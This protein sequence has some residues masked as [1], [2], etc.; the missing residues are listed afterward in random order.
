VNLLRET[1]WDALAAF[2][3][4]AEQR[5]FT[6]AAQRLHLSQPALHTKVANLAH[7]LGVTLYERRGRQIEITDA[8]RKVQRFARELEANAMDFAAELDDSREGA[9]VVLCAGE[10]AYL[11]LL[12]AGIRAHR[13]SATHPLRLETAGAEGALDAV[14]SARAHLGVAALERSPRHLAVEPLT[15]VGQVLAVP[16]RHALAGHRSAR[17][18]DLDGAAL[19]VPPQGRP[20][21]SMLAQA[22]QS[23]NVKWQVAV[24]ANGWELMLHFV[25]LGLGLA[26]VNECCRMPA[27]VVSRPLPELPALQF[28]V[29]HARKGVPDAALSLK[30]T[31]LRT[32]DDWKPR[33]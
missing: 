11:Y 20:H 27:G 8:G 6:R 26:I 29:F 30:R 1:S 9:P 13:S 5:N 24:E 32:A 10:G 7:A 4:F 12:G 19:V 22:L 28:H 2:A 14:S 15:R 16:A 31:L 3:E 21:R 25:R 33:D 18:A 17:L 23:A